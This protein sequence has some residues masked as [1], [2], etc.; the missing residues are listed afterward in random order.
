[1]LEKVVTMLEWVGV[2][3][4][5]RRALAQRRYYLKNRL[6]K[7]AYNAKRY[8]RVKELLKGIHL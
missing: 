8:E 1:M 6:K 3:P 5:K 4:K 7:K 2:D